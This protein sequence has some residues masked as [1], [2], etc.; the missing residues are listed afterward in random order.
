MFPM[1]KAS[2]KQ[3]RFRRCAG[4]VHDG[5]FYRNIPVLREKG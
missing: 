3:Q 1:P 4:V 2:A 5:N